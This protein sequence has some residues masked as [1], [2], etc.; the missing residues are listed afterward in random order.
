MTK[1][2]MATTS[3]KRT[4]NNRLAIHMEIMK[5]L[6]NE[7]HVP[8]QTMIGFSVLCSATCLIVLEY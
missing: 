8:N 6:K 1:V 4:E 3:S 5:I 7:L 2:A